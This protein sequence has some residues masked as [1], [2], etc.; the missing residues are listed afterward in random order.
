MSKKL[1]AEWFWIERW[2]GSSAAGLPMEARGLYREMLTR[3]WRQG[4]SLPAD[5]EAVRRLVRCERAE[6][7]RSWPLVEPYWKRQGDRLVNET[8][9]EVIAESQRR[10]EA[11]SARSKHAAGKR[12]ASGKHAPSIAQASPQAMPEQSPPSPYPSP[13]RNGNGVRTSAVAV[14]GGWPPTWS[15]EACDDW[16][17]RFNGEAPGGQIGKHLAKLRPRHPSWPE[18]RDAW[19]AYLVQAEAEYASPAR[20]VATYG[21]WS[22]DAPAPQGKASLGDQIIANARRAIEQHREREGE[23]AP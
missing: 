11:A 7:R 20:F 3:A 22:G 8:Q 21:R 9:L 23:E 13:S 17:A 5:L 10:H 14:P 15:R 19:R 4:G 2:E 12:W 1:L 16:I 18:V 6:W